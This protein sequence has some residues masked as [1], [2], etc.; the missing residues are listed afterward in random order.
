M[1]QASIPDF[2]AG[3][4]ENWGLLTYRAYDTALPI[5]LFQALER[6]GNSSGSFS[7]YGSDF[8]FIEYYRGWTE[9]PG[10]PVLNVNVN[11]RTGDMT[12]TQIVNDVFQF[13][14]SGLMTY[15]RAFNILS[16]LEN[17]TEYAP[18]MAAITGFSWI[19]NRFAGTPHL[20]RIEAQIARWAN[21]AITGLT[22]YPINGESFMRSYLRYQLAPMLCSMNVQECRNAANQQFRNLVNNGVEV[23]PNS[24]NWV[25]CNGLREGTEAD[26]NFLWNR[27]RNHNVYTEKIQLLMV[28]GCTPHAN[29]LNTILRTIVNDTFVIRPQDFTTTL[30]SAVT[31][32]EGNTQIVFQFIRNNLQL[33]INA[34]GSASTPLSYI[35]ARLRNE[36][37]INEFQ[38][39][40][41]QNQAL[42]GNDYQSVL[43]GAVAARESIQWAASVANDVN[44][45]LTNGNDN[46]QPSTATTQLVTQPT[47]VTAP[48]ISEPST[49]ALPDSAGSL[50]YSP[51][52]VPDEEWEE[53][54][55]TL[56]DPAYRLPTT[57]RP[58][59]Y[60]VSLNPY[61]D[62][63]PVNTTAFTFD[64][65]GNNTQRPFEI[66]AR[67]NAGST[68]EWSLEIGELL[69]TAMEEKTQI[70]YYTMAENLGMQQAAIPDFSAGAME[71]WG[72]LTYREALILYD[73]LNS[74]HFYKQRVANIVSHE[75]VHMWFGNLVTCAWWDNLW[76]NE[77]FARY[78][79]Y[80]LTHSVA[81]DLGFDTRFIVEQL[82]T[83]MISDSIDS[84]HALTDPSV[85]DPA[86]VSAHFSAITYAR[87]A[88]IIRMTQHLLGDDT[89]D[90]GLRF[91]L[92]DRKFDVAE[93]HHLFRALD[94]AAAEDNA[95]TAYGGVTIDTYFRSW[96]E[97]AGHPLL[98]VTVDQRTGRMIVV[99]SR[100]ERNTGV[101][102]FPG[103]WYVPITWTRAGAPDFE[104]L[105]PSQIISAQSTL[106]QRGTTGLEW[107]L[108]N[109]QES[110]FYRVNYDDTNWALLT[111]ALRSANRT[112]IH[113]INRAQIV[114]DLF[115]L[116]RA[117]VKNYDRIYNILS[118]LEF[119]DGYAPWIAAINGFNFVIRRLAHDTTNLQKLFGVINNLSVA[120]TRRLGYS[121]VSGESYM[122]GLLRMYLLTF[123]CNIGHQQCVSE[124]RRNFQNWK[125]GTFIPANMRPWVYC[126]GLREGNEEDFTYFWNRYLAE[127]LA[128]EKVVMLEA[129][130]CTSNQASLWRYLDAIVTL[131]DA[132]RPQDYN[133]AIN[134][135]VSGNEANTMRA[136]EWLRNN[137]ARTTA[138]LGSVATPVSNIAGRL[139]NE[140]QI[141]EFQTWLDANREA[142][143]A[144]Y[145]T[146]INGIAATR[147]NLAWS[148]Q[149]TSEMERYFEAGYVED[150]IED[151]NDGEEDKEE[152]EQEKEEEQGIEEEGTDSANIAALSVFTLVVTLTINLMA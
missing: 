93:P 72:L 64:A 144:A 46:I 10:H 143:G 124:G 3:A 81:R 68:G 30:N 52:P 102:Q 74:N 73:P 142:I 96:S 83:V 40:A 29:S 139:L 26:F 85:N 132:V 111:R 116:A 71:N 98:T 145:N 16:F 19:R 48:P 63:V 135:A 114:D 99:Q 117:G 126:V 76:L 94:A 131:D 107:V 146:G 140:Q 36:A 41:N 31:G 123:L 105:K 69:L 39:W 37:E 130:G 44:N 141:T 62:V 58:R 45:Y 12:I 23:P 6:V 127:D 53:F 110:G 25:Y 148:R 92:L 56:R 1:T 77:G 151:I 38:A 86:S 152:I 82:Q 34:F 51:V 5:H 97:K 61:F 112:V 66:Y 9:E 49:P 13:A 118:F 18:W 28:L 65:A 7:A 35:S 55:R 75:V 91:Y 42:L 108:F 80:Y 2:S 14:R 121:E 15:T 109:K 20:T 113:E 134:A 138:A 149:R 54:F 79:Q 11:H 101:S 4:M 125:N 88:A 128:S 133:V 150:I 104:N 27:F 22:Y 115:A 60:E 95:L 122:D 106:I 87:G 137:I 147:T 43:N 59:H 57:T 136:F 8:N 24:R 103:L 90:K 89:F 70:P 78:Y 33:V 17:E 47:T 32:N 100:W 50:G 84:A 129:A 21:T 119:E 67:N 120:V